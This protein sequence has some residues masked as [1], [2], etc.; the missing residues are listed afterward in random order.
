LA[1]AIAARQNLPQVDDPIFSAPV[2]NRGGIHDPDLVDAEA[3]RLHDAQ[4]NLPPV[5]DP[6]IAAQ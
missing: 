2:T 4:Q 5:D 6:A 3:N 1:A